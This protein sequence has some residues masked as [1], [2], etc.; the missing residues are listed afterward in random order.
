MSPYLHGLLWL[1]TVISYQYLPLTRQLSVNKWQTG[2]NDALVFNQR[3]IRP[4]RISL[5]LLSS[6]TTCKLLNWY[7]DGFFLHLLAMLAVRNIVRSFLRAPDFGCLHSYIQTVKPYNWPT[8]RIY[9]AHQKWRYVLPYSTQFTLLSY[10]T[11]YV[12]L[13]YTTMFMCVSFG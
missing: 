10:S 9:V 6:L 7:K 11:L 13:F 5:Y 12:N 2:S 4:S 8:W 1:E 3:Q